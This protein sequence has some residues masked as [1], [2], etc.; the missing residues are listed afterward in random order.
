MEASEA[1]DHLQWVHGILRVADRNLHIPPAT[2]IVWG[3]FGTVVNALHQAAASGVGVPRDEVLQ[4]P[5][6]GLAIVV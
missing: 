2:L 3:L 4:L 6:M 1:R 5:L